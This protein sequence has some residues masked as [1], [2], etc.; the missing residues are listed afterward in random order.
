MSSATTTTRTTA[1]GTPCARGW[2]EEWI[3]VVERREADLGRRIC[4][5]RTIGGTPCTLPS[6]H[7]SGRCR[8]HGGFPLTGA[9]AGNRNG[10]IHDLYSRRLMVCG[11]HC[12]AWQTCPMG[13]GSSSTFS[14][15]KEKVEPKE[16]DIE[17]GLGFQPKREG[18]QASNSADTH[19]Q[20]ARATTAPIKKLP[21]PDSEEGRRLRAEYARLGIVH[22]PGV[23]FELELAAAGSDWESV[24]TASG[25]CEPTHGRAVHAT[26]GFDYARYLMRLP[27]SERPICPFEQSEY[28]AI[29]TDVQ[30]RTCAHESNPMG[31]HLAH[32]V[33]LV[34]VMVSRAG[35]A[36]ALKPFTEKFE[37]SGEHS[38]TAFERPSAALVAFERLAGELRRWHQH[39]ERNYSI[40]TTPDPATVKEHRDRRTW[41]TRHDPDAVRPEPAACVTRAGGPARDVYESAANGNSLWA[42][43][44]AMNELLDRADDRDRTEGRGSAPRTGPAP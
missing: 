2:D 7:A 22:E 5:A 1:R 32:T 8:H 25:E 36:L 41:D 40:Y 44:A 27:L 19:G 14:L 4:G 10:V 16:T 13:G 23:D 17:V 33:A 31:M 20:D 30:R 18:N 34:S 37:Q 12:P 43:I 24:R 15:G 38:Y 26:A 35:R 28:Q 11:T 9:P 6:D 21:K 3:E 29:V 39:V 42:A